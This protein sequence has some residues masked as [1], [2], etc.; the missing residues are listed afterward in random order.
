MWDNR[1]LQGP[2]NHTKVLIFKVISSL[3]EG[4]GSLLDAVSQ[5]ILYHL[6]KSNLES[7]RLLIYPDRWA[8][9]SGITAIFSFLLF[10]LW[11]NEINVR[12]WYFETRG[13]IFLFILCSILSFLF[14]RKQ[15]AQA[16]R[17]LKIDSEKIIDRSK[18]EAKTLRKFLNTKATE[19]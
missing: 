10:C 4:D 12:V 14:H 11:L 6:I 19:D 7:W 5:P 2:P 1:V 3:I 15:R 13:L 9:V 16:V 17:Q 8:V 18:K